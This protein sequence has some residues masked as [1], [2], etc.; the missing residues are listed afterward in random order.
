MKFTELLS[1]TETLRT[2]GAADAD[3]ASLGFDSRSAGPGQLFF[4]VRGSASDGH[5]YIDDAVGRGAAAVICEHLPE[6]LL[7]GTAY[8]VVADSAAALGTLASRFYGEPSR[9]LRLVGVTGTNGK[10]TT[11]TLLYDLFRS[12]GYKA[13]LISTV[14]YR[15]D[16]ES[17]PST[18]TTPDAIRLNAMLAEM[19]ARGC[20][21]CF[22][23]VSSHSI[24][25]E[26]I[27]GLTFAGGVFT[28][29]THEHLDY[30]KTFAEYIRAK[31]RF[32]DRLPAE[33]FA[34]VNADDRNGAVMVQNTAA[35]AH[36]YSLRSFSDF[37]CRILENTPEG[38]LLEMDGQQVWTRFLGR[39]N[40]CNL[41]AVYGTA[42]L[43]GAERD[44]T[45]RALSTLTPVNGRFDTLHAPGGITA[46]V[47]YAHSP[48][49]LRNV[50]DTVNEL[51]TG[52][53]RLIVVVGCGGDRDRTKRPVM[54]QIA[55]ENADIAI[56][57]SDNP[58]H[59]DP[60]TIL[61]EMTASLPDNGKWLTITDRRQ[62]IRAAAAMAAP[63][64]Y[65]LIAG[66]G[67]ETYQI[68]GDSRTHFDDKEEIRKA[69]GLPVPDAER[70]AGRQ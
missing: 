69:L 12:L 25:Q 5:D 21:Y 34:L 20:D 22:M 59:E 8:A 13:G 32:F 28:N 2:A 37:R 30:H 31:K 68:T 19:V 24:V 7:P 63:G 23:E 43:L 16:T 42:R 62:A 39:F 64:D 56:F 36:T 57:T 6:R 47:D 4:A 18:H 41:A 70:C 45:L 67:H 26:R 11:A 33:A 50:M 48:D 54:G 46:I 52:S 40:A 61:A 9:S 38:M 3:I 53:G 51:R 15:I 10:T 60:D 44:E 66:K 49:A 55:A 35:A 65:I 29:I 1:G 58:R 14:V 27:A 17:L